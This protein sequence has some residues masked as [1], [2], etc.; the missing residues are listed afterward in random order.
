MTLWKHVWHCGTALQ[1]G[2][3]HG[4]GRV[5]THRQMSENYYGNGRDSLNIGFQFPLVTIS[6]TEDKQI[7]WL[8]LRRYTDCKHLLCNPP[9]DAGPRLSFR[10]VNTILNHS[11]LFC[12][13]TAHLKPKLV[14]ALP[15]TRPSLFKLRT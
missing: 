9:D 3:V 4:A 5:S 12:S 7:S 8:Y 1:S 11:Q 15:S 2:A 13:C 14:Q 6:T 10:S